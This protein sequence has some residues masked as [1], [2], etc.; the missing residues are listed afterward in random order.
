M[1]TFFCLLCLSGNREYFGSFQNKVVSSSFKMNVQVYS[2]LGQT[3]ERGKAFLEWKSI[4]FI[5]Y[6]GQTEGEKKAFLE[7]SRKEGHIV[8]LP[9]RA[10]GCH[11]R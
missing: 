3:E 10:F 7:G 11:K 9:S 1:F 8:R 2:L 6:V 4:D 5:A